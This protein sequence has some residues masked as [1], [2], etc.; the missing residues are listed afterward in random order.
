MKIYPRV[1]GYC[2][3][4]KIVA[5]GREV[6][7]YKIGDIILTNQSHRSAFVCSSESILAKIPKDSDLPCCSATYLFHLGYNALLRG[8]AKPGFSI[9]VLGLGTLGLATVAVCR[10]FGMK[11]MAISSR[12]S[13]LILASE[14]GADAVVSNSGNEIAKTIS[15][16]FRQTGIDVLVTTSNSWKDWQTA[17][18]IPRK[19]GKICVL[20]FP[21]RTESLPHFNPLDSSSFYDKQLSIIACGYSPAYDLAPQDMRF[22]LKRNCNYLL[23]QILSGA[24]PAQKIISEVVVWKELEDLYQRLAKRDENLITAVLN[25]R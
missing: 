19:L 24:L 10:L 15:Q 23:D 1:I 18:A 16:S 2:N 13:A 4:A 6:R 21:G 8:K 9:A 7:E 12:K 17:L 14:L 3:V 11:T 20:G 5:V 25:W 22:N